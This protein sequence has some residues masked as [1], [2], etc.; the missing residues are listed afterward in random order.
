QPGGRSM[1][2]L[3]RRLLLVLAAGLL[4]IAVVSFGVWYLVR[5]WADLVPTP[6]RTDPVIVVEA[7][8]AGANAQV[9]ADTVAAPIQQ[10]IDGGEGMLST[11]SQ[12]TNDGDYRLT[13]TFRPGM[14]LNMAQ[15]L[16]QNRVSLAQPT[17]PELVLRQGVTV[18]KKS[19]YPLLF[20]M[21][22]SPDNSR[23]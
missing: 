13:V 2:S 23:D 1:R 22:S 15:V 9:G 4:A 16:V 5:N 11:S 14:D 20:V 8:Y 18:M 17:L 7:S 6:V 3:R 21:L 12:C 19:P 10:Q